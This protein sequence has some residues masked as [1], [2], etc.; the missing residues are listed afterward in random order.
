MSKNLKLRLAASAAFIPFLLF[1]IKSG[2]IPYMILITG[3]IGL[4]T[5]EFIEILKKKGM[6]PYRI[7]G[8]LG[9][10]FI[11]ILSSLSDSLYVYAA[12]TMMIGVIS[13]LELFRNKEIEGSIYHISAT[14]F[15]IL[16][17]GWLGSHLIRL[18]AISPHGVAFAILPYAL[19]WSF[20]SGAY[21]VGMST[22]GKHKMFPTVSPKKSWE[23]FFGGVLGVIV[24]ILI[25]NRVVRVFSIWDLLILIVVTAIVA[26]VGDFVES[27]MK[28][29]ASVKDASKFIPGHGGILD[30]FD[31]LFFTAPFIYYYIKI[32]VL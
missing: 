16:Y 31:S 28:R 32:F 19:T 12:L 20:D 11:A 27:L 13:T 3:I 6:K 18:R 23:G 4:G 26:T 24:G 29:D 17:V 14:I 15:G 1:V 2:L 25:F 10:I 5:L 30:R 21:F 22:G 8:F 7:T 9:A